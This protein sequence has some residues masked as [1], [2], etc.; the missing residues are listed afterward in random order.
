MLLKGDSRNLAYS[1]DIVESL[2]SYNERKL[3]L[4]NVKTNNAKVAEGGTK[5]DC[6]C[7]HLCVPDIIIPANLFTINFSLIFVDVSR[8]FPFSFASNSLRTFGS[9]AHT[10]LK[11]CIYI[12]YLS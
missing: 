4:I 5:L 12:Y 11:N 2:R 9:R 7:A 3:R 1:S 8:L 10:S 6:V